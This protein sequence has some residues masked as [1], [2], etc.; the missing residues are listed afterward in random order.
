MDGGTAQAVRINNGAVGPVSACGIGV[1]INTFAPI[2]AEAFKGA[3]LITRVARP[4]ASK[5]A[6]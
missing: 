2:A 5:A 6:G 3:A 1:L 4:A